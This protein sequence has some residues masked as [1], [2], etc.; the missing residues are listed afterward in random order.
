MNKVCSMMCPEYGYCNNRCDGHECGGFNPMDSD[1]EEH[2]PFEEKLER[3]TPLVS[4]AYNGEHGIYTLEDAMEYGLPINY[5]M[6]FDYK[7]YVAEIAKNPNY[8]PVLK[9]RE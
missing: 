7:V 4:A 3:T 1:E 9:I 5:G 2:D 6:N 8:Q